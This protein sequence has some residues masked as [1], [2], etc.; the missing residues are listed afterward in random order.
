M[1]RE[2]SVPKLGSLQQRRG[3]ASDHQKKYGTSMA[4]E[5]GVVWQEVWDKVMQTGAKQRRGAPP[6]LIK[7][8][9]QALIATALLP[10]GTEKLCTEN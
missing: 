1:L 7:P 4:T 3:P 5:T 9:D 6:P 2:V 10:L 8:R